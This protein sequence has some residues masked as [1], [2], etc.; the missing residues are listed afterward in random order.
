[1]TW[2]WPARSKREQD[3]NQPRSAGRIGRSWFCF[4]CAAGGRGPSV[5]VI[6]RN[7]AHHVT[8]LCTCEIRRGRERDFWLPRQPTPFSI[9]EKERNEAR[10]PQPNFWPP[11]PPHGPFLLIQILAVA[12]VGRQGRNSFFFSLLSL[13]LA[14][15]PNSQ[16]K[17]PLMDPTPLQN[18]WS[19][20]RQANS[21]ARPRPLI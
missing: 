19:K 20:A 7:N 13:F 21:R 3:G 18:K 5:S 11:S 16:F 14:L 1:M 6:P 9:P 10:L 17:L 2:P 4:K 12:A 15:V 8:S